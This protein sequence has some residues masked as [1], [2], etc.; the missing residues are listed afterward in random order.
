MDF[1]YHY[2]DILGQL[3]NQSDNNFYIT[4]RALASY[5][6]IIEIVTWF[7]TTVVSICLSRL[8]SICRLCAD[9]T[10]LL[11]DPKGK[12]QDFRWTS[13]LFFFFLVSLYSFDMCFRLCRFI[14]FMSFDPLLQSINILSGDLVDSYDVIYTHVDAFIGT[15]GRLSI[16]QWQRVVWGLI[17]FLIQ[18]ML[19][20]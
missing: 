2:E 5:K 10:F 18:L 1:F 13:R 12:E 8:S 17:S 16:F 15:N 14:S 19:S 9:L 11:Y 7:S 6:A 4:G 20:S 3:I